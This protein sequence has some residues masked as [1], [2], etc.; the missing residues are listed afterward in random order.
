MKRDPV[1]L[2]KILDEIEGWPSASQPRQVEVQ[3]YSPEDVNY[4]VTLLLE[5]AYINA[6]VIPTQVGRKI[7][8]ASLT[9]SGHEFLD[10]LRDN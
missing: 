4:H 6:Q 8:A 1:L 2:R 3:G 10:G 9:W 5:A 7:L